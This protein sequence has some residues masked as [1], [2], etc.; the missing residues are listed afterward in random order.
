M[1]EIFEGVA[2]E[3]NPVFKFALDIERSYVVN[4]SGHNINFSVG[5]GFGIKELAPIDVA[6][7]WG[8]TDTL[9]DGSYAE[10]LDSAY[11]VS[12][13]KAVKCPFY[14]WSLT[15][16]ERLDLVILEIGGNENLK[17]DPNEEVGMLTPPQYATSFPEYHA[18]MKSEYSG[19]NTKLPSLGDTNF[20]FTK[21]PISSD[22]KFTFQTLKSYITTD[23]EQL[24][25][26]PSKFELKQNYPNP[27]NPTTTIVYSLP[28]SGYVS[29]KVVNILGETVADLVNGYEKEGIHKVL[30]NGSNT[31]SGIYFYT[32]QFGNKFISNKMLLLK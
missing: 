14:A 6:V 13:Q 9:A 24:V 23:L 28:K 18:S 5:S 30:F 20:V 11:N 29:I 8:N 25:E 4:N 3:L 12:G 17:W 15:D 1:T 31:A 7:I 16:N 26:L 21:R 19:T 22:D 32:I 10:P 2:V 27:F